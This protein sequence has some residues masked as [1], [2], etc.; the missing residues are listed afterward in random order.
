MQKSYMLIVTSIYLLVLLSGCTSSDQNN[1]ENEEAA[2]EQSSPSESNQDEKVADKE[3]E[4]KET[5]SKADSKAEDETEKESETESTEE[6]TDSDETL[7]LKAYLPGVGVEKKFT[8]GVEILVTEKIVAA[9]SEYVQFVTYIGGN[10]SFQIYK[11]TANEIVLVYEEVS[12][13]DPTLNI[14]D[15]FIPIENPEVILSTIKENLTT[16]T[17]VE[18]DSIVEVAYGTFE[19]VYVVQKTTD[20]VE[21]ADTIYTRYYAPGYGLVKEIFEVT[22]EDGYSGETELASVEN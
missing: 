5:E 4:Q 22:G 18:R 1:S 21:G 8:D 11:W 20:E 19:N 2:T 3:D 6:S 12:V 15:S 9:N 14:L 10:A 17:I 16:W 13:E 7:G